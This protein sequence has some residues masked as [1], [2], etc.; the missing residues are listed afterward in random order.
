MTRRRNGY[1]CASCARRHSSPRGVALADQCLRRRKLRRDFGA[2]NGVCCRAVSRS[3]AQRL[4]SLLKRAGVKR[5][6]AAA[7]RVVSRGSVASASVAAVVMIAA[8]AVAASRLR[9]AC[10]GGDTSA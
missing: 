8:A 7:I 10:A 4:D 6:A 3:G 2:R 1:T 9:V 5:V